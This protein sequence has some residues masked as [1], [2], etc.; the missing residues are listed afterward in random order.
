MMRYA[1]Q[2]IKDAD[3]LSL[4]SEVCLQ[5]YHKVA[6]AAS[7]KMDVLSAMTDRRK[8]TEAWATELN[9]NEDT[10]ARTKTIWMI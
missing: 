6:D 2:Q 5:D 10:S 7:I 4:V 1:I 8:A 3:T 9:A